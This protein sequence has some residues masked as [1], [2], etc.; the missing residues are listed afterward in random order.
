[1]LLRDRRE[2]EELER[3][4]GETDVSRRIRPPGMPGLCPG[5]PVLQLGRRIPSFAIPVSSVDG[6][7]PSILAAPPDPR[8][9]HPQRS[10]TRT[11]WRRSTSSS[12]MRAVGAVSRHCGRS[13]RRGPSLLRMIARSTMFRSS[14]TLPGYA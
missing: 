13:I 6:G 14:R 9:R 11:M 10:R 7:I 2:I 1:M 12:I 3:A 8:T 4:A 5:I